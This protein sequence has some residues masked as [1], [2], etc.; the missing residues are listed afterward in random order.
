MNENNK[1][2]KKAQE[3]LKAA[4]IVFTTCAGAGLGVLRKMDFD[5]AL[6]DEAS[7]ITEPCALIP[8]VKGTRQA[9]LVGDHV[10]LR[11]T[12]KKMGTALQYDV[13]L[14]ERLYTGEDVPGMVKT[15]LDCSTEEDMGGRSKGNVGQ[16]DVVKRILPM[17]ELEK[18]PEGAEQKPLS[19]TVLS[20]YTTQVQALRRITPQSFTIDSFQGRESDIII[21]SSV[22]SNADKDIGFVDDARRLNVMWTRARLALIII[23]DRGT[24]VE[25][26]LFLRPIRLKT[27]NFSLRHS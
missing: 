23:G 21:F 25:N 4:V 18:P 9:I 5:I 10:Q 6:I 13:S 26:A 1:L 24:M 17:L 14:L 15:M 8:L 2:F 27:P 19:I 22:R 12:V 16:V 11:P 3:R 20:P 7:Q